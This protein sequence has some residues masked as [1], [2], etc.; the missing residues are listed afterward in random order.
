MTSPS[1]AEID[2]LL[3]QVQ[4]V[5][6]VES[7]PG[8]DRTCG[9]GHA[10][11]FGEAWHS[12]DHPGNTRQE[13]LKRD[14]SDV[15]LDPHGKVIGG[16]EIDPYTGQKLTSP[17]QIQID[18]IYPLQRAWDMGASKW[19]LREREEF[20][21]DPD[22]LIAVS[23]PANQEK[24]WMGPGEWL[25][26]NKSFDPEYVDRYL[27]VAKKYGLPITQAEHDAIQKVIGE[28]MTSPTPPPLSV[29]KGYGAHLSML[30]QSATSLQN[31][32][33][34]WEQVFGTQK[35][36]VADLDWQGD[37]AKS[38]KASVAS[39]HQIVSQQADQLRQITQVQQ[40]SI[41]ELQSSFSAVMQKVDSIKQD[42]FEVTDAYA[43][44]DT[45]Q[46]GNVIELL[47]REEK[48]AQHTSELASTVGKFWQEELSTSAK[49]S[50]LADVHNFQFPTNGSYNGPGDHWGR[51]HPPPRRHCWDEGKGGTFCVQG[52]Q[53]SLVGN[54]PDW[55]ID[56]HDDPNWQHYDP[57]YPTPATPYE[58]AH[59]GSNFNEGIQVDTSMATTSGPEWFK[60]GQPPVKADWPSPTLTGQGTGDT[61]PF[62]PSYMSQIGSAAT[63]PAVKPIMPSSPVSEH[64]PATSACAGAHD[65]QFDENLHKI[66]DR[67]L[68]SS[69]A[70]GISASVMTD[71]AAGLP[72]ALLGGAMGALTGG[73]DVML[74]PDA[75]PAECK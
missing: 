17:S 67:T 3:S 1:P 14:M 52:Q 29:L 69:V 66:F 53:A 22:E 15:Q 11:D 37:G 50:A 7:V 20:A 46:S 49:L 55:H 35:T 19:P 73:M 51:Q 9:G 47:E 28:A 26:S 61:Q 56:H 42:G 32:A 68:E 27:K 74:N 25:P 2:D 41:P 75:V 57:N 31:A 4:V 16:T 44:V 60:G 30:Q 23:G 34:T 38:A 64:G 58:A 33:D 59:H 72:A 39:D 54:V 12:P 70:A 18:H 63:P 48:A 10:C 6:N 45:K 43:V 24:G 71:G 36:Q 65:A 62:M 13:I 21:N 5:P 8:Y 40:Q